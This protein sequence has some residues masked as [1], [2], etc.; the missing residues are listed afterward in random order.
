MGSLVNIPSG[1]IEANINYIVA[2]AGSV[3]YNTNSYT[4]GQT[5]K[6]VIGAT[7]YTIVGNPTVY[8][9]FTAFGLKQEVPQSVLAPPTPSFNK[10]TF[11]DNFSS[12]GLEQETVQ[13]SLVPPKAAF[14]KELFSDI[15]NVQGLVIE[16]IEIKN[17]Q[18]NSP[19]AMWF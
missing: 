10:G 12:L 7:N 9:D 8:Q 14:R 3:T 5:F 19:I 13:T 4:D 16:V 6:G 18:R 17:L 15:F 11:W 1:S 2:G